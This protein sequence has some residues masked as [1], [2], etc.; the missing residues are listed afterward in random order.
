[1]V[2]FRHYDPDWVSVDDG[3]VKARRINEAPQNRS[4]HEAQDGEN[5]PGNHEELAH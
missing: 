4:Y 3:L 2:L 1:L 5:N